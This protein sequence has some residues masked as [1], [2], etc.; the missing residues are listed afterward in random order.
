MFDCTGKWLGVYDIFTGFFFSFT[1][2]VIYSC[3]MC[4]VG[5]PGCSDSMSWFSRWLALAGTDSAGP[6]VTRVVV[7]GCLLVAL[8]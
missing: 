7:P 5:I 1:I 4:S 8:V 2:I 6:G 3:S